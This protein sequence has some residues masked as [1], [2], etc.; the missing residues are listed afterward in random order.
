MSA[1]EIHVIRNLQYMSKQSKSTRIT[2][3]ERVL[4]LGEGCFVDYSMSSV[5]GA[6]EQFQHVHGRS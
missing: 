5:R 3:Q 6:V 4:L 2:S 1:G